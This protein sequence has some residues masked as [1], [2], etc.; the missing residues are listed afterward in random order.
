MADKHIEKLMA[1]CRSSDPERQAEA[2]EE[3]QEREAHEALPLVVD[4]LMARLD[5]DG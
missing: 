1:D 4:E 5:G 3:L 2:I